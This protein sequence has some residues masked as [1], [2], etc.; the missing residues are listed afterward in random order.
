ME[1]AARGYRILEDDHVAVVDVSA[2]IQYSVLTIR[3]ECTYVVVSL[4]FVEAVQINQLV[5]LEP[6]WILVM[7]DTWS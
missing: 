2:E 5:Q 4:L 7:V 1:K 6:V 3:N